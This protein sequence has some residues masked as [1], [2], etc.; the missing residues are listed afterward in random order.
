[1]TFTQQ[2]RADG[3]GIVVSLYGEMDFSVSE[4]FETMVHRLIAEQRPAVLH[5]DLS[6]LRFLDSTAVSVI[7]RLWRL[8]RREHCTLR[9]VNPTGVVRHILEVTGALTIVGGAPAPDATPG[10]K[11]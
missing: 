11:L 10:V 9:V 7:V 4:S 1:L 5:I 2:V 8:A 3:A 6:D